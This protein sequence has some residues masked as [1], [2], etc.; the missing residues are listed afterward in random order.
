MQL[1]QEVQGKGA[2][3]L[4][5]IFI[6]LLLSINSFNYNS[7]YHNP[8]L[9]HP[10]ELLHLKSSLNLIHKIHTFHYPFCLKEKFPFYDYY[11]ISIHP[12]R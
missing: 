7:N 4:I 12:Y 8:F 5:I 11:T 6:I 1:N 3:P 10:D 2:V 9:I